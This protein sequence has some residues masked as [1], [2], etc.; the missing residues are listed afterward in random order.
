MKAFWKE[1]LLRGLLVSGAGP[2]VLAVIYAV[3]GA[4][5]AA[6]A[7]APAE[8]ARGIVTV[9]ALAF[10]AAGIT[11]IYQAEHLPLATA[12]LIHGGVLYAGYLLVYLL[13]DWLPRAPRGLLIFTAVFIAGYAV[14]WGIIY[15]VNRRAARRIS[16]KLSR[17]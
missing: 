15:L 7:L 5:G 3:L 13:N 16:E 6:T 8:V 11:A 17:R 12:A 14:I 9:T 10:L 4:T 2:L 1:F